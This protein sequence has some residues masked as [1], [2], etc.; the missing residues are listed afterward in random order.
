MNTGE[1]TSDT[2]DS[3]RSSFGKDKKNLFAQNVVS[4]SDPLEACLQRKTLEITNH[5]YSH[6]VDEVKPITNQKSSGR[7][8]I[9]ACL[10]A[11]RIPFIKEKTMEDFEFSQGYLFFWDKIER[12]NYFLNAIADSYR[13]TPKEE[14]GGRLVSFLLGNPICD[15]GQWDMVV[16]L[17]EKHGVMPKKCFP[18][19]WSCES[20][21]RMNAIL[22]SKLREFAHDIH[23][24][25]DA[26]NDDGSVKALIREQM[27]TIF[28]IVSICLG[29]PPKEF[30]WEY[31]DKS[32]QYHKVGN[33]SPLD[34]YREHVKPHFDAGSKVCLVTDPRPQ[35]PSGKTYT[36]DCL[37]NVVGG[38]KTIYN[39]Q[40]V[41]T[42]VDI[43]AKSIKA[44]E[45][46]WFG[47][48]VGKH[49]ASKQ[50]ILDLD[51]HDYSMVFDTQVNLNLTKAERLIYG[52]S[53]MNHAMVLTGVH[54]ENKEDIPNGDVTNGYD[55][56]MVGD[57]TK[58]RIENSWGEDRNE[59]GFITMTTKWFHEFVF[60]IVVDRKFCTP[61]ILEVY[62]LEPQVLPAWDPMGALAR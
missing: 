35:N 30:T 5:V 13:R 49:M 48:E 26:G 19:T 60:E 23:K 58:W 12:S 50:G 15:G 33:I 41:E 29:T 27:N 55:T 11:M 47:C 24:H 46:V 38:R 44:G 4:R 61:E 56:K 59:K 22:K 6:K 36:V 45:P 7:C 32:K 37:G 1:L 21:G 31:Y 9:F 42:L 57:V 40:P 52:D 8:W 51:A 18:E 43:A 28:R 16:N 54:V 3:F 62:N 10:N 53:E 17:V 20:S 25:I 34:F 39:N 2:L 14:V